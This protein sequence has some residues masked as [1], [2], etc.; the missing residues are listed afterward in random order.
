V[1]PRTAT[2]TAPTGLGVQPS[3]IIPPHLHGDEIDR[4]EG[5]PEKASAHVPTREAVPVEVA[6]FSRKLAGLLRDERREV[7]GGFTG[8]LLGSVSRAVVHHAPCTVA[9]V[10]PPS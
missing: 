7:P 1:L 4:P 5:P 9:V 3:A 8:L 6:E 2:T 10:R